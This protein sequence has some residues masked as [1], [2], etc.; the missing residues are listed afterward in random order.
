M[1]GN[2]IRKICNQKGEHT[3][4]NF[5]CPACGFVHSFDDKWKFKKD[6]KKPTISPSLNMETY[7][8]EKRI[9]CH[10]FVND[11]KIRYLGDC[12]HDMK[13]KTVDLPD[14]EEKI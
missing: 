1:M 2:K 14:I 7:R 11:G 4:Y 3:G 5:F 9:K 10:S 8:G 6:Y 13:N 12:T